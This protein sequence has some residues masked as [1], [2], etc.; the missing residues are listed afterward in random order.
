MFVNLREW[1]SSSSA[2]LGVIAKDVKLPVLDRKRGWVQVTDPATGKNG[3]IYS[4]LLVGEA[5]PHYRRKRAA[6]A[7]AE[8]KSESFW[9][10][11]GGWLSPSAGN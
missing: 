7:A 6:P 1:P 3:W 8:S 5:K 11:L 4:G 9:S 2:V 10:R